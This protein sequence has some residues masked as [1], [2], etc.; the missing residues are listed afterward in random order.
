MIDGYEMMCALRAS[1][2]RNFSSLNST[3][4]MEYECQMDKLLRDKHPKFRPFS[5]SD[6]DNVLSICVEF[7]ESNFHDSIDAPPDWKQKLRDYLVTLSS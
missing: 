3:I 5:S 1:G 2:V 4:G 7:M 6:V